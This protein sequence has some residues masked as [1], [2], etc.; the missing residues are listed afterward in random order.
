MVRVSAV[1]LEFGFQGHRI[2]QTAV[3]TLVDGVAGRIDII[4][5]ELEYEV[6]T[7]VG[8]REIL[9]KH[10]VESLVVPL[11]G[12]G[13]ELKEI[14]ERLKLDLEEIRVRKRILYRCEIYAGFCNV[15]F[16]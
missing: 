8:D 9:R 7:G 3:E 11:F 16:R 2:G 15:C 13:V 12:R 6:V 10:L 4:I 14:L 1:E 5:E